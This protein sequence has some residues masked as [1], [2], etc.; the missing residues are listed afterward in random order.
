MR[1]KEPRFDATV[2]VVV[3]SNYLN[4]YVGDLDALG[5][6]Q[7]TLQ[8]GDQRSLAESKLAEFWF[9]QA[10]AQL[11]LRDIVDDTKYY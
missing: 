1:S 11:A 2:V 7:S 6:F 8:C 10:E 5:R 3:V 9:T 4:S